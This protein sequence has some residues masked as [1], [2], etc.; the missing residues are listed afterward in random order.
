MD[1]VYP[2]LDG[3]WPKQ[4]IASL[5]QRFPQAQFGIEDNGRIVAVALTVRVDYRRFSSAHSY[6]ELLE[7]SDS[8][9]HNPHGDAMYGLDVFVDPEYRGTVSA[10]ASTT[11]ERSSAGRRTSGRFSRAVASRSTTSTLA[12]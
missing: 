2:D 9:V 10:D 11:R 3:A 12:R 4:V 8:V 7:G 5:I 6:A 1:V